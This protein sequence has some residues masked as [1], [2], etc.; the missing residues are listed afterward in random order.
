MSRASARASSGPAALD[1]SPRTR[2]GS[3]PAFSERVAALA[4]PAT[5]RDVAF[6]LVGVLVVAALTLALPSTPTYDPWSWIVWGREIVH[7]SLDTHSGPS[8][9]PLPVLFTTVFGLAGDAAPDLWLLVARAGGLLALVMV[10]R[11]AVRLT[12]RRGALVAGLFAVFA[13]TTSTEFVRGCALGN[14]EGLLVA[15]VLFAI[16]RHV[17]GHP[18]QSFALLYGAALL[19]PETWPFLGLYGLWLLRRD[20]TTWK[21]VVGLGL[22]LPVL[23]FGPELWGSGD[24]FRAG[25]RASNPN[26]NSPAFAK[27][28][29]LQVLENAR[30]VLFTP[31]KIGAILALLLG[32]V[33]AARTRRMNVWLWI[34]LA[35][36]VWTA[37][38][39]GMTQAGFSGNQRYLQVATAVVCVLAG[40]GWGW[41]V[42][43]AGDLA[44]RYGRPHRVAAAVVAAGV[45][46]L[47]F[48]SPFAYRRVQALHRVE[49]ALHFQAI[50]RGRL[51]EGITRLGGAKAVLAC[52][53]P[54]TSALQVPVVSWYLNV[55]GIDV[56]FRPQAPGITMAVKNNRRARRKPE[57]PPDFL[58]VAASGPWRF[59]AHCAP[60]KQLRSG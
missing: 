12:D 11:L 29:A 39:A 28:P 14:S 37:L 54:F 53:H 30:P 15:F 52:G 22:L 18:R 51:E 24:L 55:P 21:L 60:G 56:G 59:T 31:A 50:V 35:A 41:A 19:R 48:S 47:V 45:L 40:T 10:F 58:P 6:V 23:W 16:E 33:T 3:S 43:R 32:L 8:W 2:D 26:P 34:A 17:D 20:R 49:I 46:V 7:G 25:S 44:R 57:P 5:R 42:A 36:A 9:K 4:R 13:L 27:H 1:A 38:V